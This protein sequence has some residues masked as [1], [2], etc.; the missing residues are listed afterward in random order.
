MFMPAKNA[1]KIR[2]KNTYCQ[3]DFFDGFFFLF[4]HFNKVFF[5]RFFII[6]HNDMSPFQKLV[7]IYP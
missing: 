1:D 3:N 7:H 6:V 5:R 2:I 4:F